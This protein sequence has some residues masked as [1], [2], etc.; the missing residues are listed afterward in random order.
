MFYYLKGNITRIFENFVALDVGGVGYKVFVSENTVGKLRKDSE[1]I[2]YTYVNVKE[3]LF[4]IYG[5]LSEDELSLFEKLISVSGVGPKA[6]LSI[7]SV[8]PPAQLLPA[9]MA[10]DAKAISKAPGV[11]SKTAQRIIL[12]LKGKIDN[13]SVIEAISNDNEPV[14][15]GAVAET[16]EALVALG[17]TPTEARRAASFVQ[18]GNVENMIKDALKVLIQGKF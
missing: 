17:Y 8:L 3:D 1:A 10:G 16:T 9:I 5:F 15:S 4:D 7:L 12:E 13:Q 18:L 14:S 11:G 2:I 6:G